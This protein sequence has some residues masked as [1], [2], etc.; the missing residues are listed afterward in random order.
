MKSTSIAKRRLPLEPAGLDFPYYRDNPPTV[1]SSGWLLVIAAT[2][3]GFAALVTPLPFEDS[4]GPGRL[5]TAAFAAL[6]L[7]GLA[8][9]TPGHWK[10][11][12]GRVGFRE[13][14]LMFVFALL[15]IVISMMIGTLIKTFGTATA[16]AQIADAAKL[17][18]TEL[19]YF[20]A[21]VALQLFGE[22]LITILPLLAVLAF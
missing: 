2:V 4:A 7:M 6:P 11:I 1:S 14:R 20:F 3:A 16:N 10:A 22:E 12:F 15:N 9:A 5:R 19:L 17:D 8:L 18:E 13:V 21:K